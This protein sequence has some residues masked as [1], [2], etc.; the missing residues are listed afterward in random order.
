M[1]WS[2]SSSISFLAFRDLRGEALGDQCLRHTPANV[3]EPFDDPGLTDKTTRPLQRAAS[4]AHLR[5]TASTE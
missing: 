1:S 3:V 4:N 5:E 2:V